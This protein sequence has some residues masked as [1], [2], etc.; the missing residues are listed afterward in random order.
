MMNPDN[1]YE[2]LKTLCAVP[3]ISGSA[4]EKLTADKIC[5]MLSEMKYFI[6]NP[7]N[8]YKIKVEGDPLGRYSIAGLVELGQ[9]MTDTVILTGHYDVVGT[10]EYGKLRDIAFDIEAITERVAELSLDEYSKKDYESGEW[11]FGRGTADMKYG[12]SLC[13]ELIRHYSE[14]GDA[15]ELKGNLLFLAVAAEE[16][17]SEGMLASIPFLNRL[18]EEK[19]L[20]YTAYLLTEPFF[21]EDPEGD[22]NKYIHFGSCGKVMPVFMSVG[23]PSHA[24]EP[25]L[26]FDPG[27]ITAGIHLKLHMN[28]EL[29]DESCG[30][31]TPPPVCLKMKDMKESYSVTT[32]LYSFA[33]YSKNTM[34]LDPT[35]LMEKL[36][37][38]AG[39]AMDEAI[40]LLETRAKRYEEIYGEKPECKHYT[41]EVMTYK[42]LI[43]ELR[44]DYEKNKAAD[45]DKFDIEEPESALAGYSKKLMEEGFEIQDAAAM[46][47]RRAIEML[48]EKRPMV[49]V[50]FIPPF[51]PDKHIDETFREDE[52]LLMASE[53]TMKYAAEEFGISLKRKEWFAGIS[54]LCYT[55][56]SN[57][58]ELGELFDNLTGFGSIYDFPDEELKTLHIPG[59]IM[60]AWG[61]DIHKHTERLHR[62]YNFR[63][64]PQLYCNLI[65]KLMIK[66]NN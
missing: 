1:I 11:I 37:R 35:S 29:C 28:P 17:N 21:T 13:M 32:P 47:V 4:S 54:D 49:V 59:I 15:P 22:P 64:L 56:F 2:N 57:E 26:G 10:E 52:R 66:R 39:E 9:G 3:G 53:D 42:E 12:L 40:E 34:D 62:D 5:S 41:T 58:R 31:I 43:D 46:T 51:Y 30:E 33:Y 48:P 23:D 45:G 50:G 60:G 7:Q 55:G 19:G 24:G 38:I 18:A 25:F 20:R 16:T 63:V 27:L 65:E 61:K 44:S 14:D 8:L 6:Q 36:R